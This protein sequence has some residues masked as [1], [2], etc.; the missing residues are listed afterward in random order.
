MSGPFGKERPAGGPMFQESLLPTNHLL[1]L[2]PGTGGDGQ[3]ALASLIG[4]VNNG[5]V[6]EVRGIL[7]LISVPGEGTK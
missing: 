5:P 2:S 7:F 3:P 1:S 4:R 6:G